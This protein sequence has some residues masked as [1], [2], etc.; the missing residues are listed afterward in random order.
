MQKTY[1][2][3]L[4]RQRPNS[5]V[6]VAFAAASS[7]IDEWARVPTKKTGN[8]RNFQRAEIPRHVQEVERFFMDNANASPTAVVVGF[9]PIR[10]KG[11]VET[12]GSSGKP[13]ADSD[14]PAG[15]PV[16]GKIRI[17]WDDQEDPA[18]RAD[19]LS[20]IGSR[21]AALKSLVFSDLADITALP[22]GALED[23][24]K[25][26]VERARQGTEI[27]PPGTEEE[28]GG[29]EAESEPELPENIRGKLA[30]L[31]PSEQQV[32]AGR[33]WFLASLDDEVLKG[34][35][36]EF[37]RE[38]LREARDELKPGLL[39]DGQHRIHGTKKLASIPFL[40]TA[41]PTAAW[42]ELAF[43]FIVTNRTA[44]RVPES[45]LI[46]II[47]NSLSKKQRGEI[48]ERLRAANIRVGL[49]EAVMR[50]HED[51]LSPFYGFI[52]FGLKNEQGFLDA[53]AFR[54]KVIHLWYERQSPVLELF[55]HLCQGKRKTEKTEFWKDEELWFEYFVAFWSAVRD[56]YAGTAVFSSETIGGTPTSPLMTAT[57]LMIFQETLLEYLREF[58][59][60]KETT[61]GVPMA[62]SL[63]NSAKL[64]G[65]VKNSLAKLTPDFFTEWQITGFDGSKG[66]RDDLKDAMRKVVKGESTVAKLKKTD[67]RLYKS[68]AKK[69]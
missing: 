12:L 15:T 1:E 32:V 43:Q 22:A 21:R 62:T 40:V 5:P 57:V 44:R 66:A 20:G 17:T 34:R 47:G 30:G 61:E 24:L 56:R 46:S 26:F 27:E 28:E 10:G 3:I 25:Y 14:V 41:L 45:L 38:L 2:A 4:F 7:E 11:K 60:N 67:H 8:I 42:P 64:S 69:S 65:L 59:Q 51:E 19:L 13:L 54:G 6:Q 39:I 49:I 53:A 29:H 52:S 35:N 9:D 68:E 18:T 63:P 16:L 23:I 37:L 48:E 55:D 31:S 50:V 58:L 36:D 33:L